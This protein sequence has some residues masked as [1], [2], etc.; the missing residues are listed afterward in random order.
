M[1]NQLKEVVTDLTRTIVEKIVKARQ[2]KKP[3]AL[4]R[5]EEDIYAYSYCAKKLAFILH[6]ELIGKEDAL[7]TVCAS[8][9]RACCWQGKYFCDASQNADIV[10][11][12]I[13]LLTVMSLEHSDYWK[14][15][16]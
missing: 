10:E 8:C 9:L 3:E 2:T 6:P 7:I 14:K 13:S 4:E 15:Q 12:P 16:D 11:L 5:L 1:L